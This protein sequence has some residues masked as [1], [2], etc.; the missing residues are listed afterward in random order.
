MKVKYIMKMGAVVEIWLESLNSNF[1]LR[2]PHSALVTFWHIG[3]PFSTFRLWVTAVFVRG[4]M[5]MCQNY[6]KMMTFLLFRYLPELTGPKFS[7]TKSRW[8][9]EPGE[10]YIGNSTPNQPQS[11]KKDSVKNK[12]STLIK[13]HYCIPKRTAWK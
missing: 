10:P 11:W 7:F 13:S 12:I 4:P 9:D 3:K 1:T 5:H 8:H 2:L 6:P